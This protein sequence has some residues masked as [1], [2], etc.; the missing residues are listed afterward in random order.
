MFHPPETCLPRHSFA[1]PDQHFYVAVLRKI[2]VIFSHSCTLE[3]V[4]RTTE[5]K[6]SENFSPISRLIAVQDNPNRTIEG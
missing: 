1:Q 3:E 2:L 5:V 4:N 6:R